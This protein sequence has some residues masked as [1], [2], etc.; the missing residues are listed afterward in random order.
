MELKVSVENSVRL[1]CGLGMDTTV[2]EVIF[3]IASSIKQ[4]GRFYL[5]EKLTTL[6]PNNSPG[7]SFSICEQN[8]SFFMR[9]KLQSCSSVL[10]SSRMPRILAPN[11]KIIDLLTKIS[12]KNEL[13]E[14]HLFRSKYS[15]ATDEQ[16]EKLIEKEL[17]NKLRSLTVNS[18]YVSS[19]SFYLNPPKP[20]NQ[21]PTQTQQ[22]SQTKSQS[23]IQSQLQTSQTEQLAK[24]AQEDLT[25]S[26]SSSS[27]LIS[28]ESLSNT[29]DSLFKS[30]HSQ[31]MV[32]EEQSSK[33]DDLFKL[34]E[35]YEVAN[36]HL[37]QENETF[38]SKLNN[39]EEINLANAS[40][41]VELERDTN[42]EALL[43][44]T[45]LFQYLC[46]QRDYYERKLNDLQASIESKQQEAFAL[47]NQ[48]NELNKELDLEMQREQITRRN[49]LN[50]SLK[51][52]EMNS[53][54]LDFLS[55]SSDNIQK[56]LDER[57]KL[58]D[59][60]EG[61]LDTSDT[62]TD[63]SIEVRPLVTEDENRS[64]NGSESSSSMSSSC[65]SVGGGDLNSRLT[66]SISGKV[67]SMGKLFDTRKNIRML[68]QNNLKASLK[69]NKFESIHYF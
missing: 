31:Q 68:K 43:K 50:E 29:T 41:L 4:T 18:D 46:A 34:I 9:K 7:R 16:T 69:M 27:S 55:L 17:I 58:I 8:E 63:V 32:L 61:Q 24:Q 57:H 20:Q 23:Q 3:A 36:L 66:E 30:I 64:L 2:Q 65:S 59:L 25:Y 39:L 13:I 28:S 19:E 10:K 15:T 62:A 33:L 14:F 45:E 26:A 1:I 11:E 44:E 5:I 49:E 22:H 48:L 38:K 12:N 21:Q 52:S 40:K 56:C 6:V 67:A 35:S 54:R 37:S 60:L 53:A 51:L 47:T 42:E